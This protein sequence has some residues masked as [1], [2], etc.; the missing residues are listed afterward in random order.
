VGAETEVCPTC[1]GS[2]GK[3]YPFVGDGKLY[4]GCPNQAQ[5]IACVAGVA[6]FPALTYPTTGF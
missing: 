5:T 4:G 2:D 1:N 3:T 6:P